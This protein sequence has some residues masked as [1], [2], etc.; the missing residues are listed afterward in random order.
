[1]ACAFT[2]TMERLQKE[3]MF[4]TS[5]CV[6]YSGGKDSLA[7]LDLC[8]RSFK[9]VVAV[10]MEF[11]PGLAVLEERIAFAEQ[12]WKIPVHRIP[13]WLAPA[14]LAQG[15][16]CDATPER[17]KLPDMGIKDC[18][19]LARNETGIQLIATGGKE[20]D[21]L[22]RR[23]QMG[24]GG[25]KDKH[26]LYPLSG[27]NKWHVLAYLKT[28]GIETREKFDIDLSDK[29]I[30]WLHDEHPDDFRRL[31]ETFKYA[32]AAIWRQEW[33]AESVR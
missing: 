28:H 3:A 14:M 24:G 6:F 15:V 2:K 22:W 10:T 4:H 27:W 33:F 32:E 9:R 26:I 18:Y 11:V 16:F 29:C 31:C 8:C 5:V 25:V 21:G 1:M 30:R 20:S 12:R 7:A 13:H 23:R 19:A 17:R